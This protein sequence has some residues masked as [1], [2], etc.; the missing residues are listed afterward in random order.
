M[1][2]TE[3]REYLVTKKR[4]IETLDVKP[5]LTRVVPNRNFI[6]SI[7]G[8]RRSG[9]TYFLYHI[10]R[11]MQL[12]EE[13][14]LF[15]DFE[16][17]IGIGD[18]LRLPYIHQELYGIHPKYMFLDEI[19]ALENWVKVVYSFHAKKR[20]YIFI[21]GSS[22]KL[23]AKEIATQLRG[24]SIPIYI[25]PFSL[26]ETLSVKDIEIRYP[27][28][29]YTVSTIKHL[30]YT[31]MDIGFFPDIVL[32]N[33]TPSIFFREYLDL[34]IYK[35]IIER[36]GIRNRYALEFLIKSALSSNTKDFSIRKIYNT[37]KSGG[38]KISKKTL[39]NFQR[40]LEDIKMFFF[41]RKF[42]KSLRR[43]ELSTPKVYAIDTGLATYYSMEKSKSRQMEHLVLLELIK[44]GLE[45]N[46]DIFYWKDPQKNEID[47]V[48]VKNDIVSQLIQVT[49]ASAK[50]EIMQREIKALIKAS[51][52]LNCKNLTIIT[53]DYEDKIKADRKTIDVTPLWKWFLTHTN[54]HIRQ[55]P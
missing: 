25:Y 29:L 14:F 54:V 9:K 37:L 2:A 41:L 24:R 43:I 42:D 16:E 40:I 45:P 11:N 50:D 20:Y 18:P 3:I 8:P 10:I 12:R 6:I 30:M 4:D 15:V 34:V 52:K 33:I 55:P 51:T 35:D 27:L 46:E 26:A 38:V 44:T 49:Y 39:Y 48:I 1:I 13:D 5:R 19:Q 21:T 28:D 17:P 53:W 47:F 32:G 7:I 36:Y 23:L 22:S 31:H